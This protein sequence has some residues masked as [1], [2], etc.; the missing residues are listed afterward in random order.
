[1]ALMLLVFR[2][3][4]PDLKPRTHAFWLLMFI[5]G[6]GSSALNHSTQWAYSNCFMPLSL[7]AAVLI[8]LATRDLIEPLTGRPRF[9]ALVPA[10]IVVQ[11]IAW[12]YDPRAQVPGSADR[13]ALADLD[14]RLATVKGPVFFPA[15]P[16][17]AWRRDGR[18]HT[19]QMGIQDVAFMG[20][21][22]D[23]IPRLRKH[24]WAAVIVDEQ[25]RVPGLEGAYYEGDRLRWPD[26]DALR[27]KTGF[28][29]RPDIIWFAQDAAE[30]LLGPG[31]SGN[32]EAGQ[33]GWTPEGD[34]FGSTPSAQPISGRQGRV[35][36]RST[37]AGQGSLRSAPVPIA[38]QRLTFLCAAN[39]AGTVRVHVDG[40]VVAEK[41]LPRQKRL[42]MHRAAID[43]AEWRGR[44]AQIEIVDADARGEVVIDD[45]RWMP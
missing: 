28:L 6:A 23:L 43:L 17:Y 13:A 25:N 41:K 21:L 4:N 16:M 29:V 39:G 12:G 2:L 3:A 35:V 45:L 11:F 20:G 42:Q 14:A 27:T 7:F 19:H 1:I 33:T 30:R 40:A 26:H 37:R 18:T 22:K 24:E 32:F 9:A 34:A 8:P 38:D 36:V 44:A 10:A 15:H 5:A 31:V